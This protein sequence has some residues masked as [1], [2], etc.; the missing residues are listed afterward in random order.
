VNLALHAAGELDPWSAWA[1]DPLVPVGLAAVGLLYLAGWLRL[2]GRARPDLANGWRAAAFAAGLLVIAFA[3]VSPLD[4]IGEEY[5]LSAHMTQHMLIGD[6]GPALL[7]LG[8]MGPL[9]L[10]VV[11]RPVLRGLARPRPRAVLR[12]IGRPWVAFVAWTIVVFGWHLPAAY[13]YALDNRWAHDL[14]HLSMIGVGLAVWAHIVGNV[15]RV[16]MSHARRAAY[17]LGLFAVGM[18]LSET[19]FL[20]S[21]LYDVYVQ[22]P[23]RLFGLSPT[24]DQT[25]AAL[26]M[27]AEQML[28]LITAAVLLMWT[29]VDRA[30][31]ER[32]RET[33]APA[34]QAG[35]R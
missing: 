28:T 34:P 9:A 20:R 26:I 8:V 27:T 12:V 18:V 11:P 31:A 10:F 2:R 1:L 22:Q 21:P 25:R 16:R 19:L 13:G 32:E 24:A 23:D 14:E 29:H 17:A 15:P 5:L 7:T 6:L 4:H 3:L 33:A 35:A 30:A